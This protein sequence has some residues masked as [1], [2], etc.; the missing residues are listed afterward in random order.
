MLP[1]TLAQDIK[2]QVL[3][4]LEATFNFRIKEEEEALR[5]FIDDPD[6]G[7]FKGPW[8]QLRRPFRP[9]TDSGERYFDLPVPFQPFR[10][11]WLAWQ[12]LTSKG[13]APRSTLVTTG[14]GSGKT[15]CFLFPIL[16]HCYREHRAQRRG[17]KAIILYPMNALA[18]DQAGRFAEEIFRIPRLCQGTGLQRRAKV[19]VGLYTGRFDPAAPY[20]PSEA[21]IKTMTVTRNA[22][23]KEVCH[24]ITDQETLQEDPPDILLTNYKMLDFLLLRPKDKALW[25]YNAPGVLRYLVLDELH[26]YDGAQG[27]DVACLIRRLKERLSI[28]RG[29]LCCIGTSATI[30]GGEDE[31]TMDP[32]QRL[33]EFA[34]RLFEEEFKPNDII[35]EDRLT[36]A[37]IVRQ[38]RIE[39]LTLPDPADCEPR[40]GEAAL[41]FAQRIAPLWGAPAYPLTA[42]PESSEPGDM[43]DVRWA[44]ELGN[45]LKHQ[46][47]FATLLESTQE[48]AILWSELV[49]RLAGDYAFRPLPDEAARNTLVTAFLA[50]VAQAKERRSTRVYPLIPTQVQIWLREL[51]RLGRYVGPRPEFGWLDE[52]RREEPI[53]PVAHC[54]ECGEAVWVAL[55]DADSRNLI[56]A[57]G[58]QG[59][60]LL[61][62]TR[63]IYDAWGF[64]GR[65]KPE[66]VVFSPWREADE[67]PLQ[68]SLES[69]HWYLSRDSL[70][71]RSGPGPCPLSG[72]ATFRIKLDQHTRQLGNGKL[73]GAVRCP[74]CQAEDSLMFIG[75]R[76]ATLASVAIDEMFGSVL[77]DDPKLLAFTDSVQDASHRAGFFSARTYHFTFRTALR[78]LIEEAP[79][80]LPLPEVGTRLL[81]YWAQ[82]LPGRPGSLR[83]AMATLLPPDLRDYPPY[84][85][86]R[87]L[88]PTV[89]PEPALRDRI[90]ERLNWEATSEFSLM[91]THGR[92]LELNG[93]AC[94][95][96]D[97]TIIE[98]TLERLRAR[99]PKLD[100]DLLTVPAE[101]WR[102]WV[103][104]ILHRQR[105]RGGLYHPFLDSYAHGNQWGKHPFGR[106]QPERETYPP[107]GHY[108]PRLLATTLDRNHDFV[109]APPRPGQLP[110]WPLVWAQRALQ[111]T[112]TP[113]TTVLDLLR[114]LLE[115]GTAAGL[116]HELRRDGPKALYAPAATAARLYPTGVH[117][118]CSHSGHRLYR[119]EPEA[120]Y[121]DGAPS[122]GYRSATGRYHP[123]DFNERQRYYQRRYRKGAL[124]RVFAQEH[125]GLLTTQERE[126]L[127]YRFNHGAHADDPNVI[128]ATSTLELGIDIGD[129]SS[130]LLCSVPPTTA[131][132]LQRIG[133]AGRSTGTALVLA[134]IEQRPHDLFFYGRPQEMLAGRVETPGCWLDASAVLVRQYL[135]F[136][137]DSGVKARVVETLPATGKQLLDDLD[138]DNGALAGLLDWMAS[139]EAT[140]QANFLAR[141]QFDIQEDTR[142]FLQETRTA[143]LRER[144]QRVA[145]DFDSRR[146]ALLNAQKRLAEQRSSATEQDD[147]QARR[148]IDREWQILKVRQAALSRISALEL[149]IEHG[150]LPNYAFPERGV[151]FNGVLYNE[152]RHGGP[153]DAGALAFD[154][155]RGAGVALRELAPLNAF[156]TH[157]HEFQ[158]QQLAL[159]TRTQSLLTPWAICG[160]C[161]HLRRVETLAQPDASPACPQCGYT[162]EAHSQQDRRQQKPFLEFAQSQAVSYMEYYAS[163]SGDKADERTRRYYR[164]VNSFDSTLEAPAGAVGNATA[165][166]GIEYRA[167]L[168]LRQV[169]AGFAETP[170]ELPFGVD[171]TVP[172]GG[173]S[174][175]ADCGMVRDGDD[176]TGG[177]HR[178]SCAGR[179]KTEKLHSEGK[180]GDGYTWQPVYLYRELRSEAIRLLLPA[181]EPDDLDTLSACLLL[182]LRL[183]FN[184]TPGYLL[185]LP[186]CL[187]QHKNGLRKHYLVLLDAVPGGTGFL[188]TLFQETNAAGLPGEGILDLLRRARAALESCPCRLLPKLDDDPD[189]CY[190]CIRTYQQ[191]YRAEQISRERGIKLLARL[192]EAGEQRESIQALDEL[193]SESLFGSVLEKRFIER[194]RD[195]VEAEQGEWTK[196]IIQGEPGFRL[197]LGGDSRHWEIRLQP[198]LGPAQGVPMPCRPDFLLTTDDGVS[199][200]IAV[201]TDGFDPHVHPGE[202]TSR[203]PDDLQKRRGLL[204][205]G[206]FWVWSVTW[207]D[208]QQPQHPAWELLLKNLV[209]KVLPIRLEA[210]R[211]QGAMLPSLEPALGHGFNQLQAFL[212]CP[213]AAGWACLAHETGYIL[214][215]GVANR[216]ALL[217]ETALLATFQTWRQGETPAI[218]G[219]GAGEW[220]CA[221]QLAPGWNDLFCYADRQ[222]VFNGLPGNTGF[223]VRLGDTPVERAGAGYSDRWRH[224]LSLLN[225]YQ[226]ADRFSFFATSEIP[227]GTA[228]AFEFAGGTTLSAEWQAVQDSIITSLRPLVVP[229][230]AAAIQIPVVEHYLSETDDCFAE[231]AWPDAV[232]PVAILAGDQ[233]EFADRWRDAGWTAITLADIQ[234]GGTTWLLGLLPV[235]S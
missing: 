63:K 86:Y 214:L 73:V 173:F 75:S 45:W 209:T 105:E 61:T 122:L 59:F 91:L 116:L 130:T 28:P 126:H 153:E 226:F 46:S 19:R 187:P 166:F 170:A 78:H 138:G 190:R 181:V 143:R 132:Y 199:K 87:D 193:D 196:T 192:I 77:N 158:I 53:L 225:L 48:A 55:A 4:Y 25:R 108:R 11:Q 32:W 36:V 98:R 216:G 137:F 95:G 149:L 39:L 29:E 121:W 24:A 150:L 172:E 58:V 155:V 210:A 145:R 33:A 60:R 17:I 34:G 136:C 110:S 198:R 131:S 224:F 112:H 222:A 70:V 179:R 47:L 49:K 80:G 31:T 189:G 201:F 1:A 6:N 109:L 104:G 184:G 12:R 235:A 83:E 68:P 157:S 26:T 90:E 3:H 74:H 65:M 97:E 89:P 96:W 54:S 152:H 134:V 169:N 88:E 135:A 10:H 204:E 156:Y 154:I 164:L 92:T 81:D 51:R 140:L 162:A 128:T 8:V 71:V 129:L 219:N 2:Q 113:E 72:T 205:S 27:A 175:C 62:D 37:E 144:M 147:A 124:R 186:H 7:L 102:L 15:E 178:Q 197:R 127:E 85:H 217:N 212:R 176:E 118:R 211:R 41:A 191:Q 195:W 30:A 203:L 38:P 229:L 227:A 99:L 213:Q 177:P 230:A 111:L 221:W 151:H 233:T 119:P 220:A 125:T 234:A 208:V 103:Y 13:H 183:R 168:A 165:P 200:P 93:S 188:K 18:Y 228:P 171:Q 215:Y 21:A 43:P 23:G 5:R 42:T 44:L 67:T 194:L 115:E 123:A 142:R 100:P 139:Q 148:E 79:T 84:L 120:N 133:R 69:L 207:Q 9:A 218:A 101:R 223:V 76:A 107:A 160:E 20:Q 106:T 185:V 161:G 159:G 174:V 167:S 231:L 182:G 202:P 14:T 22:E 35:G 66:V 206:R 114:A 141:F 40:E 16:D 82:P 94:L 180:S 232:P 146:Q 56:A 64:E 117:L 57:K 163:L 50:L 52:K